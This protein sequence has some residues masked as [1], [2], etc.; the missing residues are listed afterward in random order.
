[1]GAGADTEVEVGLGNAEFVEEDLRHVGIVML[2]GVE[3]FFFNLG[4]ENVFHRTADGCGL[5]DLGTCPDDGKYFHD[6]GL[7]TA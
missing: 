2:S 7:Q 6:M 5:D 1:M 3:D 4:G